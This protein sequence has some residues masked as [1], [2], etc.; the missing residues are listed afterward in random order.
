MYAAAGLGAVADPAPADVVVVAA[1]PAVCC[2][3]DVLAAA[4]GAVDLAGEGVLG[5]VGSS[6][7][8]L[9]AAFAED[10]LG[11]VELV[12][13]D[14]RFVGVLDDDAAELLLADIHPVVDCPLDCV[15]GPWLAHAGG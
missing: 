14:D 15:L 1:V 13:G 2:G 4:F 6:P 9:G 7:T 11:E 12:G 5:R 3:A 8:N 10:L